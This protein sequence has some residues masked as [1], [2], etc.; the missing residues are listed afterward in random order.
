MRIAYCVLWIVDFT[1][2]DSRDRE[3]ETTVLWLG[4]LLMMAGW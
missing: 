4:G 3:P 2:P 1:S